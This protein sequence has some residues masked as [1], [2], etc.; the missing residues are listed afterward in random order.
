MPTEGNFWQYVRPDVAG[1]LSAP[2][3]KLK[4][5]KV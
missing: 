5:E 3:T 1:I 2:N 4:P